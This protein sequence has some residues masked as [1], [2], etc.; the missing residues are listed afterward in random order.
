MSDVPWIGNHARPMVWTRFSYLCKSTWPHFGEVVLWSDDIGN[1]FT[2]YLEEGS[3]DV[4]ISLGVCHEKEMINDRDPF[5]VDD[6]QAWMPLPRAPITILEQ[7]AESEI[8]AR[9]A[10]IMNDL[11]P[12]LRRIIAEHLTREVA[13]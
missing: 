2:G 3:H 1:I 10:D 7:D 5:Y 6:P 9:S 4:L 8:T 11:E 13:T 12:V